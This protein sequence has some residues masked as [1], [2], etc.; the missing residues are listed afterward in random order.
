MEKNKKNLIATVLIVNFNNKKYL[1][2]CLNSIFKQNY[3]KCEII[4]IDDQSTDNSLELLSKIKNKH[5][6]K[7]I[8]TKKKFGKGSFNQINAFYEGFKISKG[9]V[10]FL[11]DSDDYFKNKKIFEIMKLHNLNKNYK[12]I[13]DLPIK[14]FPKKEIKIYNKIFL[15]YNYWPY[16]P[17]TSCISIKRIYFIKL[18]SLINLKYFPDIWLDFRIGIIAKYILKDLIITNKH[19][20]YYRQSN[21]NI[22][23]NFKYM[24]LNWWRRRKEAHSYIKYFFSKNNLNYHRNLDYFITNLFNFFI[25]RT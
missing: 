3:Q 20:T 5:K 19:L 25:K 23:S 9:D 17:P 6:I 24:S 11:L 7:V 4:V 12:I 8:K 14:K 13:F 10:I 16:I 15:D 1:P 2:K 18:F 22:S 21:T